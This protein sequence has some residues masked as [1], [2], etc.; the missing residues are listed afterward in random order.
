MAIVETLLD[1]VR[2]EVAQSGHAG[3]VV[4]LHLVIGRLSGVHADSIRFAFELLSPDSIAAGA[5]LT[6]DQPR[7]RC[8][9][10][11]CAAEV[12]IDEL[13]VLC[14]RCG[15]GRVTIVG[16]QELVLESI[17]LADEPS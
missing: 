7:A 3:R 4:G 1:Q 15:D 12:E 2:V 14:P 17:D 9:C 13:T 10:R 11:H 16:G 6:I 8:H 5:Q